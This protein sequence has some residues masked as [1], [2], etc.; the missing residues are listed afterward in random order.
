MSDCRIRAFLDRYEGGCAILL[1][2][3]EGREA[4]W[5]ADLL[6]DGAREG[7]VLWIDLGVDGEATAQEQDNVETIIDRLKRGE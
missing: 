3:D 4:L 6:P 7:T 1:L 2:G 5:P